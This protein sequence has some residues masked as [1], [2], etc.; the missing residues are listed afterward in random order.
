MLDVFL[1]FFRIPLNTQTKTNIVEPQPRTYRITLE[2]GDTIYENQIGFA[3]F[4]HLL[5]APGVVFDMMYEGKATLF[6]VKTVYVDLTDRA[7]DKPRD[8]V[9]VKVQKVT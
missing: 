4:F 6:V 5:L 2:N 8:I 9:L 3:T 1:N 7:Y